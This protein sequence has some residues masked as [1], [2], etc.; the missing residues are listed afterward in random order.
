MRKTVIA[1]YSLDP[2]VKAAMARLGKRT[3][4]GASWHANEAMKQYIK[5]K[6]S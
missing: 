1:A 5:S 2:R 6:K 4:I 3:G